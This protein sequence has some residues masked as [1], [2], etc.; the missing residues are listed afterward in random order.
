MARSNRTWV[1]VASVAAVVVGGLAYGPDGGAPASGA[2]GRAVASAREIDAA[3][4]LAA[5]TSGVAS[6][7]GSRT[8]DDLVPA[9]LPRGWRQVARGVYATSPR[10]G[11]GAVVVVAEAAELDGADRGAMSRVVGERRRM[12]ASVVAVRTS[13]TAGPVFGGEPGVVM[14]QRLRRPLANAGASTTFTRVET[15]SGAVRGR[16]FVAVGV[17]DAADPGSADAVVALLGSLR[18]R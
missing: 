2:T 15:R 4:W 8:T 16:G 14:S 7:D 12:W 9:R 3:P 18:P 13:V 11:F 6:L 1:V 17:N 10:P 5:A